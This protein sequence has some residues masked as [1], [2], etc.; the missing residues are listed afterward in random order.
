MLANTPG[1]S[2]LMP[3]LWRS[4]DPTVVEHVPTDDSLSWKAASSDKT[5]LP[6]VATCVSASTHETHTHMK[7]RSVCVMCILTRCHDLPV[8]V[9]ECVC[10][11]CQKNWPI[12]LANFLLSESCALCHICAGCNFCAGCASC[13]QSL[14]DVS[15]RVESG[16]C[17]VRHTHAAA[18]LLP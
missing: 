12:F 17:S 9:C 7:I 10:V 4:R 14:S 8:C 5:Q 16:L 3:L 15:H 18:H 1:A 13:I 11:L 6:N 2:D